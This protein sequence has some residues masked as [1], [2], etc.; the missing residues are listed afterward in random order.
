M[1]R[2]IVSFKKCFSV[3]FTTAILGYLLLYQ[4]ICIYYLKWMTFLFSNVLNLHDETILA[5]PFIMQFYV[6][7]LTITVSD[8]IH[9]LHTILTVYIA[10]TIHTKHIK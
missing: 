1:Q 3:S 8:T 10:Y 9:I 2:N 7:L 4:L 6:G 5:Y